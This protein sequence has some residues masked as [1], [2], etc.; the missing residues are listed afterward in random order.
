VGHWTL[1]DCAV[2]GTA[3]TA[4]NNDRDRVTFMS[5]LDIRFLPRQ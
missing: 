4:I 5:L 2:A 1:N 3:E